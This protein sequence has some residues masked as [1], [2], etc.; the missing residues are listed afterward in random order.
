MPR[1]GDVYSLPADS[2]ATTL[3]AVNSA[4]YNAVLADFVQEFNSAR[5]VA[6]GGTGST[7]P[8]GARTA[9]GIDTAIAA[10][11]PAGVITGYAG[12]TAPTGWLLCYGQAVSRTTYATLFAA[13][14]TAHGVGDG[15]TTF[16][17]PDYRGRVE[18]GQD[19]MGGVSAD[20]L[21]NFSGGVDG[22]TLGAAGGS[23]KHQLTSAQLAAH[24]HTFT[25][26]ALAAHGHPTR[27]EHSGGQN[28]D[29]SGGMMLSSTNDQ[30]DAA[31]TG[32]PAATAGS[33]VGG[34]SAGTPAGTNSSTGSDTAHNN[35]QPTIIMNKIIKT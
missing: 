14:G 5:P 28:S 15:A 11:I 2:L 24:T 12:T 17:L 8:A 13:I 32:V 35:V 18:A 7:T 16:N 22:D 26:S 6:V 10:A 30:T 21:T 27:V 3:T 31:I 33:Q 23:E 1:A 29:S 25:G 4:K 19:D 20:R 9:L 34:A